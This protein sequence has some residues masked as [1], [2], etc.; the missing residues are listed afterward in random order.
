MCPFHNI[1]FVP[2]LFDDTVHLV[3]H[4]LG[5]SLDHISGIDLIPQDPVDL[6]RVP[7]GFSG[8]APS[9]LLISVHPALLTGRWYPPLVQFLRN[10]VGAEPV[11]LHAEDLAY[12][13]GCRFINDQ[14]ID[15][16]RIFS[17]TIRCKCSRKL[18]PFPLDCQAGPDLHRDITAVIVVGQ[19]LDWHDQ[20][21]LAPLGSQRIIM[22]IDGDEAHTFFLKYLRDVRSRLNALSAPS[23]EVLAHDAVNA[24]FINIVEQSFQIRPLEI[25]PGVPIID[26]GIDKHEFRVFF[27]KMVDNEP[28]I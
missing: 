26:I 7:L 15:V 12:Y 23:A 19:R 6:R 2:G 11:N 5:P 20:M 22:I 13:S 27:D 10:C 21:G 9:L 16:L 24:A 28:L 4:L 25:G 3:A 18:S 1:P 8:P 14:M 17:V